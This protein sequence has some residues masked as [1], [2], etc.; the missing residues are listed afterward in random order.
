MNDMEPSSAV[1]NDELYLRDE[2]DGSFGLA[3]SIEKYLDIIR[4]NKL[5]IA[6]VFAIAIALGLIAALLATEQYRST[7]RL[8]ISVAEQNVTNVQ[9]VEDNTVLTERAY[10]P[11]QYELLESRSLARRVVRELDLRNDE[12]F[13]DSFEIVPSE[14]SNV[15]ERIATILLNGVEINPIDNSFLV[16]V[17]FS[18]PSPQLSARIA[19]AW[20]EAYIQENLNRKYGATIEARDFLE[21]RLEQTR[22]QL[23]LAER[24]LI[25]YATN[26]GLLT[27]NPAG[28][29]ADSAGTASQTLVATDLSAFNN[30]LLEATADRIAA[31]AA[32]Q[33]RSASTDPGD[34]ASLAALRA[35]R[36]EIQLE[37][38]DLRSRFEDGYPPIS[39]LIAQLEEIDQAIAQEQSISQNRLREH[40]VEAR[41]RENQLRSQ[42]AELQGQLIAQR[43]DSVQY[44]ILQR[45]VDTNRELYAGLLQRYRE[46]GVVGVGESNVLVV[47]EALPASAPFSPSIPLNLALSLVIAAIVTVGGVYL[48][49][50]LNQSPRNPQ[51]VRERLGLELLA[52]IPKTGE[53]DLV[54]DLAQSYTALYESYFS[55]A[56]SLAN[57]NGGFVPPSTMLTSSR[58]GEGKSLSTLALAY[59]LSRQGKRV[60]LIDADLRNSGIGKYI[61]V[62]SQNGLTQY[63]Q[64]EDDYRSLISPSQIL[65]GFEVI[66]AGRKSLNVAELLSNGRF[67]R[68]L[69][70]VEEEYDHVV[71]D[72]PP[73]LGLVDAPLIAAAINGIVLVIEANEGKWRF[74]EGAIMRLKQA[75]ARILGA[76]VTKLDERNSTYGYGYG[77]GYGYGYGSDD[78]LDETEERDAS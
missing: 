12:Q 59:M 1:G 30:A 47:D 18:S 72:G 13:I 78:D 67:Q 51:Q 9:G 33:S 69:D 50:L 26:Q 16:D 34:S 57:A 53:S 43:N 11:T 20:A 74:I 56:A 25:A 38:A 19:N 8:E 45:E 68:L 21:E 27:L 7:V 75:N 58:A 39:A 3:F 65:E 22:D 29:E 28:T 77:Q 48:Y 10:L 42:V 2:E 46:I 63:L 32:L 40:F 49:D 70:R 62:D 41:Q 64:G 4:N 52:A 17:S 60:L 37:L 55:F 76:A 14:L 71:I 66:S 15:E 73:V 31:E 44:N 54:D 6:G 24:E 23:E 5:L 35:R 61:P 36:S